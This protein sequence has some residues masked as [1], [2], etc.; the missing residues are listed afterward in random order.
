MKGFKRINRKGFRRSYTKHLRGNKVLKKF[1]QQ[2]GTPG[3]PKK[4]PFALYKRRTP[5][6]ERGF[7]PKK[8]LKG[9]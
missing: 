9:N 4:T 7:A 5:F 2:R 8:A 6:K 1:L 3:N